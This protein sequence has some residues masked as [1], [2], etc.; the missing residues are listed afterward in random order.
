VKSHQ[1]TIVAIE[2]RLADPAT[3]GGVAQV[4]MGLASGL[5]DLDDGDEEFTFIGY[6]SARQWLGGRIGGPCRL[7]VV[8]DAT[9]ATPDRPRTWQRR[10]KSKIARSRLGPPV[11]DMMR[12]IRGETGIPLGVPWSDGVAEGLGAQLIHF[13]IQ[14]AYL[15]RL[16]SIYHPYDLQHIHWPEF[17]S[18]QDRQLRDL[19]YALYSSRATFVPVESSWTKDDIAR[20]FK[21]PPGKVVVVAI[22][23]AT[24]TYSLPAQLLRNT[25]ARQV[26]FSEFIYYPAQTWPH[27][28][29][30]RLI[31]A[32]AVLKNDCDLV[33]PL[34]CSGHQNSFFKEIEA[35]IVSLGLSDQVRFVGYLAES[36]IRTL[37]GLCK[38]VVVPTKFDPASLPIWEAFEA[39]KPVACSK[40]LPLALQTA[41]AA[42]M[43]DPDNPHEIAG[44]IKKVWT[45][46]GLRDRLVRQG[47][48]RI[49][50]FSWPQAARHFRALYRTALG[51]ALTAEDAEILHAAP[52]I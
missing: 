33:V 41:G 51:C 12:L 27:K 30:I 46:P 19:L 28:N 6:E 14:A 34:V 22:P 4:I 7:H 50:Q 42:S 40:L 5:S 48:Q 31:E 32:L 39:G 3:T 15:T 44:V 10:M 29:H 25:M 17:F 35:K 11:R 9:A 49:A 26:G 36:E 45:D 47:K 1:K 52:L 43:F 21:L 38:L 37:Y 23:P 13:P 8:P 18:D 20:H 24:T 2:A 16:P